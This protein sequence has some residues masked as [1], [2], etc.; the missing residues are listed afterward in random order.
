LLLKA[1][2]LQPQHAILFTC[3]MPTSMPAMNACVEVSPVGS[4][5]LCE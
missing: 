2:L 3:A 5:A 4:F 1:C